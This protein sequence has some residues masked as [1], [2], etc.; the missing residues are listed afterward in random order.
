MLGVMD[1]VALIFPHQNRLGP[2]Y[3]HPSSQGVKKKKRFSHSRSP[4]SQKFDILKKR[5]KMVRVL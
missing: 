4:Y 5:K 2:Q 1:K 3:P